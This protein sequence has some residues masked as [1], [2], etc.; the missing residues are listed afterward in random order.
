MARNCWIASKVACSTRAIAF[1][2]ACSLVGARLFAPFQ[3][4]RSFGSRTRRAMGQ[5][6]ACLQMDGPYRSVPGDG[7]VT[8][9]IR[10]RLAAC[11]NSQ[12]ARDPQYRLS[13]TREMTQFWPSGGTAACAVHIDVERR[14]PTPLLTLLQRASG[15]TS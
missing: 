7:G 8:V 4:G 11:C 2:D 13:R 5:W 6:G 14:L 3:I 9:R 10:Y 15:V 1:V 12:M